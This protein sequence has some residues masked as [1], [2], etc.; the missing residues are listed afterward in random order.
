MSIRSSIYLFYADKVY[1][2]P[3]PSFLMK[4]IS[5]FH[6][7]QAIFLLTIPKPHNNKG[8]ARLHTVDTRR[9]LEFY[10]EQSK[11]FRSS[12]QLFNAFAHR[13]KGSPFSTQRIFSWISGYIRLCYILANVKPLD[14][15]LGHSTRSQVTSAAFLVNMPCQYQTF[16]KW[17]PGHCVTSHV[18]LSLHLSLKT[19]ETM[20]NLDK[21]P[22]SPCPNRL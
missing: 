14:R 7:N 8:E 19:L 11:L 1:L 9:G 2:H 12:S 6:I 15:V 18:Y 5:T 16:A 13:K 10:L 22:S 17:Q 3:Y 21:R 20:L 4:A